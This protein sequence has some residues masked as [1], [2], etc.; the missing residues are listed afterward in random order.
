MPK[1]VSEEELKSIQLSI[2]RQFDAFCQQHQLRYY[3]AYGTLLG[4][5]RH[6]G[7]IPWDD[8]IDLMMPRPDYLKFIELFEE[9][10]FK[11]L[12]VVT[13]QNNPDY[14]ATFGKIIDR[15]TIMY[16]EYGQVEKVEMGVY[17]DI[18]PMDGLPENDVETERLYKRI[19]WWTMAY[20]LSIR[21]FS[22]KSSN[23]LKWLLI[24]LFSVPFRIIGCH[25]FILKLE[26]LGMTNP[27]DKCSKVATVSSDKDIARIMKRKHLEE[28]VLV[29]FEGGQYPAPSEWD[30]YLTN[31]YGDY[32]KPPP[33]DQRQQ[34]YYTVFWK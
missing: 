10:E 6:K 4:A 30:T 12:D 8:D 14:F 34:H 20:K 11:N 26:S 29:E 25:Y 24:T 18:F 9:G 17:I 33:G 31:F 13:I 28:S 21:K 7:Y 22:A 5:I 1:P 19:A 32:M 2:L 23:P 3:L 15:R 27:Y 16:Q